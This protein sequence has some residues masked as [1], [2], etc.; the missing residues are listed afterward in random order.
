MHTLTII[1]IGLCSVL[2]RL[3]I[4]NTELQSADALKEKKRL[5]N[6]VLS[7][8][9]GKFNLQEKSTTPK[10]RRE[11]GCLWMLILDGEEFADELRGLHKVKLD[12]RLTLLQ[13][14]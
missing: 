13:C 3:A 12:V 10:F 2:S 8:I 11:R 1:E 5:N 7:G 9:G 14:L 4:H 6:V